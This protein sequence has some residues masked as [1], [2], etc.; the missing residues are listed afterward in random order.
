L[1]NEEIAQ[2]VDKGRSA[3]LSMEEIRDL[4]FA[5]SRISKRSTAAQIM[6]QI[7]YNQMIRARGY[8]AKF[9]TLEE[10]QTFADR[11]KREFREAGLTEG[12]PQVFGSS[13][14]KPDARNIDFSLL[15]SRT[16]FEQVLKRAYQ[17]KAKL[18]T[19]EVIDLT[20]FTNSDFAR[21]AEQVRANPARYNAVTKGDLLI[22]WE[23]GFIR[24]GAAKKG[25]EVAFGLSK[26][27]SNL[28]GVFPG[29]GLDDFMIVRVGSIFDR[30][31]RMRL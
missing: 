24:A 16:Q 29:L 30:Q 31:P 10:F 25:P 8:P 7:E 5:G 11:V 26:I 19:G 13:L 15:Q 1:T 28:Q 4:I 12:D 22:N 2:I 27:L 14:T 20:N 21:L 3:G 17:G 9:N 6:D 23:Q 18:A